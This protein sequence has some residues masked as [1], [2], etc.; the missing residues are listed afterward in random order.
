[1]EANETYS[2]AVEDTHSGLVSWLGLFDTPVPRS[3]FSFAL[4][5][6]LPDPEATTTGEVRWLYGLGVWHFVLARARLWNNPIV[7]C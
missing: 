6:T 5:G 2:A 1:L 3:M 7:R 4:L